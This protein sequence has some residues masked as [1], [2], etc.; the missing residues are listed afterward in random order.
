MRVIETIRCCLASNVLTFVLNA[1][2][3]YA[4]WGLF[5]ATVRAAMWY[6]IRRSS[7][8]QSLTKNY[9]PGRLREAEAWPDLGSILLLT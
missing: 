9:T 2:A 6:E 8:N 3:R 5:L 4:E 1:P 7:D